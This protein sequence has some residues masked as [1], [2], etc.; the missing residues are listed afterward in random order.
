[1]IGNLSF[2]I[3]LQNKKNKNNSSYELV[4]PNSMD[5][6]QRKLKRNNETDTMLNLTWK[7]NKQQ[8]K[9]NQKIIITTSCPPPNP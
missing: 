7:N 6:F 2:E 3:N 8:A 5:K 9:P 1:M 4:M